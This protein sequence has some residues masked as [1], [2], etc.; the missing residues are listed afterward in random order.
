V[1]NS[2]LGRVGCFRFSNRRESP[3]HD[4]FGRQALNSPQ[5]MVPRGACRSGKQKRR[6]LQRR[7]KEKGERKES[8]RL[9]EALFT[10]SR[11]KTLQGGVVVYFNKL[12]SYGCD[13]ETHFIELFIL[14]R[15]RILE[16]RK[17][18]LKSF[19][20][21]GFNRGRLNDDSLTFDVR[22]DYLR[23]RGVRFC[24]IHNGNATG[25]TFLPRL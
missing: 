7:R 22:I 1:T 19:E 23:K 20:H 16:V 25:W 21:K 6:E 17:R 24:I 15:E 10:S 8:A 2:V 11:Q 4:S 5:T 13:V 3:R 12:A 9:E 14:F 18:K